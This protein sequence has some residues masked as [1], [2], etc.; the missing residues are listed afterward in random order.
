[1]TR[2][3]TLLRRLAAP[4]TRARAL[5][6]LLASAGAAFGAAAAGV[7]L[8]PRPAAVLAAWAAV[9]AAAA[10]AVWL[11]ARLRRTAAPAAM[12]RL[13]EAAGAARPG[14]IVSLVTP[15]VG[16]SGASAELVAA[17]DGRG[18]HVV[19]GAA[20]RVRR[21]LSR[22]TRW[23]L[24]GGLA[25]AAVGATLLLAA[26]P[27]RGGSAAFWHPLRAWRDA[28]APVRIAVDRNRVRSGD[29]VRVIVDVPGGARA[30]L[31]RRAPGE[32][33]RPQALALDSTGHATLAVGP[34]TGDLYLRA[35][36]GRRRSE[37]VR[38]AV[39]RP[40]FLSDVALTARY[41]AYL[42]RPDEV[43]V[44]GPDTIAVPA[45]TTIR[46]CGFASTPLK[47]AAWVGAA[48][49]AHRVTPLA[50]LGERF[51]GAL[52]PA[53][54]GVWTLALSPASGEGFEGSPVE[55]HLRVVPDSAP[56][57]RLPVPDRDTTLPLTLRQPLVIDA[58]DDHGI[59]RLAIVSRRVSRTGRTDDPVRE[60]LD[61]RGV[62]DHAV[63]QTTLDLRER[64]LLPGDTMRV[65]VEAWD[66]APVPHMARSPEIALRLPSM[67]EL[68]A[69][70]RAAA[71]AAA[72][73]GEALAKAQA[74]IGDRTRDL[75]Q[76]RSRETAGDAAAGE[77]AQPPGALPFQSR[78]RAEDLMRGQAAVSERIA[79]LAR[80][81]EDIARAA[82]AAGIGD[83]SFQARLE[84]VR[85][86][87]ER[88]LTPEL[89]Q[90]LREL[91]E[92][93]A[94]L[95]PE[96]TR[97]ALAQLVEA[98]QQLRDELARSQELFRRAAA[99]G[100]LATLAAD[101]EA[102][103]ERQQEWNR[104][105][106]RRADSAAAVRQRELEPF[107]DSLVHGIEQA[108][109]DLRS[110]DRQKAGGDPL[111]AQQA[112]ARRAAEAMA[113]AAAG[114]ERADAAQARA[115]G[116]E[117]AEE[118]SKLPAGLRARR[119]SLAA[120]WRRETLE[121]LDRALAETAGLAERQEDVVASLRRAEGG[122]PTRARQAAI[123]EGMEAI[124]RQIREA[125]SRHAMVSSGI[126]RALG[127]GQ[128][129]M[130]AARQQLEQDTPNTAAAAVLAEQAL[131]ALN[132]TAYALVRSRGDVAGARSGTGLQEAME[133]LARLAGRQGGLNADAQG[134]MSLGPGGA[135]AQQMRAL[136][137]RQRALAE[138]LERLQ[139][140][141]GSAAAGPLAQEARELARQLEQ[142]RFDRRTIERQERLHRRLLDAGR[143]LTGEE[144]DERRERVSHAATPDSVRRAPPLAPGATGPG[145]K[146]RYPS[147]EELRG[148]T[149]GQRRL[150]LEYFRLL[151]A[152]D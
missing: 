68:R 83:S 81:V 141:G 31:W 92:A 117:A 109:R 34:V 110:S 96:A 3:G 101:A 95:D 76:T 57:I 86:L 72:A 120:A 77:R 80:A 67:E 97:Q 132:V 74:E 66:N 131:G 61:V 116:T 28:R 27:A 124:E 60:A 112:G 140:G 134:L 48:P 139:A 11:L 59:A 147:W 14:S 18:E 52:T 4:H 137:A 118:L 100:A 102:L 90:R 47:A 40:A 16:P 55:L 51:E 39:E 144:P 45:G 149:P 130:R 70:T 64:A 111:A 30:V 63:L 29:T 75:A 133:Q 115:A 146:I 36:S 143:T 142:G 138:E 136:A 104:D 65:V 71:R 99:E 17:A 107:A 105:A 82:R 127:F 25:S 19:T 129:Q 10:G 7:T 26:A 78:E 123:E 122:A 89:E 41:P 119:D 6:V 24:A 53:R 23:R 9:G 37:E 62:G 13:V 128:H 152:P 21:V 1:M 151:N 108:A 94:R 8:S 20:P 5:A 69:E 32:A 15:L 84:E 98:Q 126:E 58:Q 73:A 103:H 46:A 49:G 148:L 125:S 33:W 22:G 121:A 106:A 114:A 56:V 87:L 44:P 93:L 150:V 145:V 135:M 50:V 42:E 43:L 88:A 91:Q 2:T 12:A 38:I 54:S 85:A 79:E 113:E 35:A